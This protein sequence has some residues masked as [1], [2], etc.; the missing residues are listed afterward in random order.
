MEAI[1]TG[2]KNIVDTVVA[3]G[4]LKTLDKALKAAGL[5]DTLK[6][7]GPFTLF[8]PTDEAFAKLPKE[9]LE[10]LLKPESK[11]KLAGILN[12]HVVSGTKKAADLAKLVDVKTV[13]GTEL[14]LKSENGKVKVGEGHVTRSDIECSNGVVHMIETVAMPG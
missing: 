13:Q 6:G 11:A 10:E 7:T 2:Q 14:H 5:I 9:K 3:Q 4:S 1:K 12:Y 8:A